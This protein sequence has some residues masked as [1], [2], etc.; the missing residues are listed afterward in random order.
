VGVTVNADTR[1][2]YTNAAHYYRD[3]TRHEYGTHEH[4]ARW[5]WRRVYRR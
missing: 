3:D 4:Y 5:R 1:T 2:R